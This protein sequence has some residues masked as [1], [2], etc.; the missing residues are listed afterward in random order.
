MRI[1]VIEDD[2]E[3]REAVV[4]NLSN[5][6][7]TVDTAE[8][9]ESGSYIARTNQYNVIILDN[10]LPI[11]NGD[12]VCKEIRAAG[13]HTPIIF[14][15]VEY[16]TKHKVHVLNIGADDY[17]T[18][19]IVFSEL[20]AR[21]QAVLRRPYAITDSV[22]QIDDLTID[23]STQE[24]I[25]SKER[26][27]LTRKEYALLECLARKPGKIITRGEI[28]EDAWGYDTNPFSNT[29]EAHIRNLRKKIGETADNK[30]IHTVPGRGYKLD[31]GR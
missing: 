19:P 31:R 11:K 21:I 23:T 1:L 28:L 17:V 10:F 30:Y 5:V 4:K 12:Q 15:S 20:L 9:G 16:A 3:I 18:K 6:G 14:M 26:I 27:Y 24:V 2:K 29:I 8:D 7:Y 25:K 13:I 22:Y